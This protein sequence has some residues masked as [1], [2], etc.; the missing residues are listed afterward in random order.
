MRLFISIDLPNEIE[1]YLFKLQDHLTNV[2]KTN[3]FHLT[4]KFLGEIN[5]P[6]QVIDN[7]TKIKSELFELK[8][9]KIGVFPNKKNIRVIW[10]GVETQQLLFELAKKIDTVLDLKRDFDFHPHVTL[11]R[12]NKK[13]EFPEINIEPKSFLINEF[14]LYQSTLTYQGP[15]YNI[16]KKF[17]LKN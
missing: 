3:S 12:V 15:I 1:D 10:V 2:N 17:K 6:D 7:L 5:D 11:A 16:I 13:I 8:L 14:V 4:L 9:S